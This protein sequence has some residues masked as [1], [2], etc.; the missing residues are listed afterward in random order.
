MKIEV[1]KVM[2]FK[3]MSGEEIIAKVIEVTYNGYI[4]ENVL[5]TA[6]TQQGLQLVPTLFTTELDNVIS[7]YSH[8]I[9]MVSMP[10]SDVADAYRESTT[11]IKVPEKQILM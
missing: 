2:T 9:S 3:L 4:L 7:V 8:A 6:P 10:R 11:G 1:G 5:S